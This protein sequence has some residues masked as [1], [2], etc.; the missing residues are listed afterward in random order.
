M[1]YNA[2]TMESINLQ[3]NTNVFLPNV[4]A[5][6]NP[7][8]VEKD[9]ETARDLARY[10]FT[11]VLPNITYQIRAGEM[12]I[13]DNV[14]M[15]EM[16]HNQGVNMR[17]L[18]QLAR[19]AKEQELEDVYVA[20][21]N[22]QRIHA[23]P[24]Y[25]LELLEI[26]MIARAVKH[27]L[28][29]LYQSNKR[30]QMTPTTTIISVLNHLFGHDDLS[31]AATGSEQSKET[32]SSTQT[33]TS[34]QPSLTKSAKKR[35][36]AKAATMKALP[37]VSVIPEIP[38][39]TTDR[40]STLQELVTII[41]ERYCYELSL[42][43]F[44]AGD[45]KPFLS[46]R[47][48]RQ[49]LLRR[50]CQVNGLRLASKDY[51]LDGL[52]SSTPFGRDDLVNILPRVK[53]CEPD[54]TMMELREYIMI[55]RSLLQERNLQ[56]SFEYAQEVNHWLQQIVGS[57]H[58]EILLPIDQMTG[59][60]LTAGDF[61]SALGTAS[62]GLQLS[63]QVY[64]LDSN[65]ALQHHIQ[66]A[67]IYMEL[68]HFQPAIQHLYSARYLTML[69]GG[70]NHPEMASIYNHLALISKELNAYDLSMTF[71]QTAR[72]K[73]T[74]LNKHSVITESLAEV[75][76]KLGKLDEALREQRVSYNVI[77]GILGQTDPKTNE[78]KDR[79][80]KYRRAVTERNVTI[81]KEQREREEKRRLESFANPN[82]NAM[83]S[84]GQQSHGAKKFGKKSNH[85][86]S[87]RR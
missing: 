64:G 11:E 26:E 2:I 16:L 57:V 58:R 7:D 86:A 70:E 13:S 82:P 55:S 71:Y 48:N 69:L 10:L 45:S 75:Y 60:F 31:A 6:I 14:S 20:K 12:M 81:A 63:V 66:L 5:D 17:Y 77:G 40:R 25:W 9:E 72:K 85:K 54:A 61:L 46:T 68:K 80:E 47:M 43:H 22:K 73:V 74:D 84:D 35:Q 3:L 27:L 23:M 79:L 4:V 36:K 59:I 28:R 38:D 39:A 29:R 52:Q 18:G 19:L 41:R 24:K 76:L 37:T 78:S 83:N 87:H 44:S 67:I 65:E 56:G 21:E 32:H 1:K 30:V 42:A 53:S 8:E 34:S 49:G 50:L 15:V 51:D 33:T 62:K